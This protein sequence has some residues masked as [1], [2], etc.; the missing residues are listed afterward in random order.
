M[1][2]PPATADD[3]LTISTRIRVFELE[4]RHRLILLVCS[5]LDWP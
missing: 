2:R 3:F 4:S 5:L 1:N